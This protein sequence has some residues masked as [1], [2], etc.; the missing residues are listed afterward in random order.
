MIF[1]LIFNHFLVTAEHNQAMKEE[2]KADIY[3]FGEMILE[4]ITNGKITNVAAA[5][6]HNKPKEALMREIY[7]QN[8]N[9]NNNNNNSLLLQQEIN[10][11]VEVALL[12]TRSKSCD[13][14][15]MEEALKLLL[16]LKKTTLNDDKPSSKEGSHQIGIYTTARS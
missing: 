13:R 8:Q 7:N 6:I 16:G 2:L 12:C 5:S 1:T 15:S 9:E 4:I 11:V 3:K 14:P 10:G